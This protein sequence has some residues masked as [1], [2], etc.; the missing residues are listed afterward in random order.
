MTTVSIS[1]EVL[2]FAESFETDGNGS[3]YTTSVPEFNDGVD[4]F[5]VRTDGSDIN[6][7]Y[8]VSDPDGEF[9]LAA[10]DI[11]GE[12]PE[13]D[14]VSILW[15]N[16]DISGY[17]YLVFKG[18]FAEDDSL[19]QDWDA[20]AL[21]YVEYRIDEGD[22]TK[23]IQF[24]SEGDT[25][26][27]PGLDSDFDGLRDGAVLTN[28]F[29]EFSG[30]IAS[31]GKSLDLKI[32]IEN[33]EAGDED[34]AIDNLRLFGTD[35]ETTP[36]P[37]DLDPIDLD[38]I[39]PGTTE[40]PDQSG[41]ADN[42]DTPD[43]TDNS[44]ADNDDT[45]SEGSAPIG[46]EGSDTKAGADNGQSTSG[47]TGSESE[48]KSD[49]GETEDSIAGDETSEP[50]QSQKGIT[51]FDDVLTGTAQTD[52]IRSL[53][54]DDIVRGFDGDDRLIGGD[55][56]DR[57]FGET[58]NDR[59]VG[60]AD[61][62]ILLGA[63]GRDRLKGQAGNDLL[64]GGADNDRLNSGAGRDRLN[65]QGGDDILRG[66]SSRDILRGG[67]GDDRLVGDAGKDL[68]KT[69][70]GRDRILV[71][72]NSGFDRVTDFRNN[73]DVIDL[74]GVGF[75]QVNLLQRGDDVL[76]KLGRSN[77]LLLQDTDL[78]AIDRADFV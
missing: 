25:N 13:V 62:D 44:N 56:N 19:S 1:N 76:V 78:N 75:D 28:A 61:D 18:L 3:R 2:L 54:G 53:A 11:D 67:A 34:I 20:N 32:T 7:S 73:F 47:G 45:D 21:V 29:T 35:V 66:G 50:P 74:V 63:A 72:S 15:Q 48:F 39:D 36:D 6:T 16:I 68:I 40:N 30:A 5:F 69:G 60:N 8:E 42:T 49:S 46:P 33:L 55:G 38:P 64:K 10:M 12:P 31:V 37:I 27:E 17:T 41:D 14:V 77:S 58:G 23:L 22:F 51:P 65:G 52:I 9:Y 26:T 24:A 43:A 59:L 70:G 57:L 71:K 4:D